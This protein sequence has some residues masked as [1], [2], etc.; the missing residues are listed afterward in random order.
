MLRLV[1]LLLV[2]A[3]GVYYAWSQGLLLPWGWAPAQQ[4][5]PYRLAQQI[6]PE[7]VRVLP[8]DEARRLEAGP[9]PPE[10]LQAGPFEDKAVEPLRQLLAGW[11]A[12]SWSLAPV[13]E[14]G[15]W[16]V[17]MGKYADAD[18]V[19][20][21]KGELRQIG[22]AFEPLSNPALEPGL[23]L[24]GF[25]SQA[26]ADAQLERLAT[27]GV[28]TARVVQERPELRGQRLTLPAVDDGLRGRLDDLKPALAGATLRPC[29]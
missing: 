6:R 20:R 17:Y 3:N 26:D 12:G 29:R 7:A 22:V 2:L 5:E 4:E 14:P 15:R 25:A 23:S 13:T 10:C 1:A 9:R 18:H 16:I 21:K 11:P 28:R 19:G 27:R 24:G 8:A